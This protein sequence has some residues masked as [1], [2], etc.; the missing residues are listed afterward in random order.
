MTES[1]YGD[2]SVAVKDYVACV[3][4]HRPPHNFFDVQLIRDL[5]NAFT[6]SPDLIGRLSDEVAPRFSIREPVAKRGGLSKTWN[7]AIL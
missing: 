6:A 7:L 1:R 3:E 4:I 2:V 5:A